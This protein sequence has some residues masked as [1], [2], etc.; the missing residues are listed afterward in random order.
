MAEDKFSKIMKG[1]MD[2]KV[3]IRL[4]TNASHTLYDGT[5]IDADSDFLVL[6]PTNQEKNSRQIFFRSGIALITYSE[7]KS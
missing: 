1:L 4:M 2:A 5:I 7:P 6:Q 3:P